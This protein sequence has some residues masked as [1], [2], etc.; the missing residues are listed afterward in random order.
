MTKVKQSL[1]LSPSAPE[2][3]FRVSGTTKQTKAPQLPPVGNTTAPN[4]PQSNQLRQILLVKV[5]SLVRREVDHSHTNQGLQ[6]LQ[7]PL[8]LPLQ[9]Q[10]QIQQ[11]EEQVVMLVLLA[12]LMQ[13]QRPQ[14]LQKNL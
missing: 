14:Q 7:L 6:R 2:P 5:W 10:L 3:S 11:E 8:E 12:E 13:D 1:N 9:H 4:Q